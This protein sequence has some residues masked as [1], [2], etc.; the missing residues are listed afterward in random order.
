MT[1][2]LDQIR[3]RIRYLAGAAR[4]SARDARDAEDGPSF[5]RGLYRGYSAGYLIAAKSLRDD[6]R[7]LLEREARHA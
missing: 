7:Y 3:Y 4:E 5:V 1:D 6:L 2:N